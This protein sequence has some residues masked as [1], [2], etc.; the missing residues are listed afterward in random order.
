MKTND[1]VKQRAAMIAEAKAQ[2]KKALAAHGLRPQYFAISDNDTHV[3][4]D[5]FGTRKF[6][7]VSSDYELIFC[8]GRWDAI[9]D[10]GYMAPNVNVGMHIAP[11]PKLKE[12]ALFDSW[13]KALTATRDK[14]ERDL[15][16]AQEAAQAVIDFEATILKFMCAVDNLR[17]G[18]HFDFPVVPPEAGFVKAKAGGVK[19]T[20]WPFSPR[21]QLNNVKV[22]SKSDNAKQIKAEKAA[23]QKAQKAVGLLEKAVAKAKPAAKLKPKKTTPILNAVTAVSKKK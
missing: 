10:V 18:G 13:N 3:Q 11:E 6:G 14:I 9:A 20:G 19:G 15:K 22:A 21:N 8:I 5:I 12:K 1:I 23:T 17:I 16:R 7:V 4:V 2:I